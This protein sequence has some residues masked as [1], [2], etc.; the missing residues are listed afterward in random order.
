MTNGVQYISFLDAKQ[1]EKIRLKLFYFDFSL[2]AIPL[3]LF[4]A[5]VPYSISD[6]VFITGG[7]KKESNEN[8]KGDNM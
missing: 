1:I 6:V 7:T 3:T 4:F 5:T 8:G 2:F